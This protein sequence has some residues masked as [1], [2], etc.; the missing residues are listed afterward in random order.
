MYKKNDPVEK[1][2]NST[3]STV[4]LLS[5]FFILLGTLLYNLIPIFIT[6]FLKN[7]VLQIWTWKPHFL[8]VLQLWIFKFS[9]KLS[10]LF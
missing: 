10:L 9:V 4:K 5:F 7:D 3:L 2:F 8:F 1:I 6:L